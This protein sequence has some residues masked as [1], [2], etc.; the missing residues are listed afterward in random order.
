MSTK[1]K[2]HRTARQPLSQP[3]P[4]P[5]A[6][7]ARFAKIESAVDAITERIDNLIEALENEFGISIDEDENDDEN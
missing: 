1:V 5:D 6:N 7:A 2:V 3:L 4:Q